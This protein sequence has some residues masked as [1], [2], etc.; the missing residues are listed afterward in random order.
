L[1]PMV[2]LNQDVLQPSLDPVI[3]FFSAQPSLF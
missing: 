3:Y 2:K 1:S